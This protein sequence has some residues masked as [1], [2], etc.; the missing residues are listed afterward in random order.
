MPQTHALVA[1]SSTK[2]LA[3]SQTKQTV[4]EL[5][6]RQPTKKVAQVLHWPLLSTWLLPEQPVQVVVEV[7]V[8]HAVRKVAHTL[9]TD[10]L[11]A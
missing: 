6:L 8:R 3:V 7:Q 2:L 5:Q 1:A 4:D 11:S 9:Q 10:A